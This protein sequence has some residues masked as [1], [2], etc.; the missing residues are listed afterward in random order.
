MARKFI[1]F[2]MTVVVLQFSWTAISAYCAHETGRAAQHFGHHQHSGSADELASVAQDKSPSAAKK[3][4][5]HA[6]CSSCSHATLAPINLEAVALH[7]I[8]VEADPVALVSALASAYQPP[9]ERPQ[10][11]AAV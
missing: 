1:L 4:A 10:W 3:L 11:T 5:P 7:P 9:P 8:A 2:V 6:H